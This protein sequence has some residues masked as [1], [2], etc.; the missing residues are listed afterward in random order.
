[1]MSQTDLHPHASMLT[2]SEVDPDLNAQVGPMSPDQGKPD[3]EGALLELL[4]QMTLRLRI[5]GVDLESSTGLSG[6]ELDIVAMLNA[7]GPTS[8][9]SLVAVLALPRS[10]MT[11][12]IDRLESRGL[13]KRHPNPVDRRSVILEATPSATKALARYRE[14]MLRFVEHV[15][16]VLDPDEQEQLIRL[17]QKVAGSL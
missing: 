15:K 11:A 8:V 5:Q 14:E 6:R 3:Q 13:V 12:I 7:S 4:V 10:T 9:K 16:R 2:A 17:T 1:M